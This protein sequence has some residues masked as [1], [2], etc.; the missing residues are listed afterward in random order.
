MTPRPKSNAAMSPAK[1]NIPKRAKR[2]VGQ[3]FL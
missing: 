2:T 3:L 1:A